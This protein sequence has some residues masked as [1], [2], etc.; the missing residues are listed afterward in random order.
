MKF[1]IGEEEF[2]RLAEDR[3]AIIQLKAKVNADCSPLELYASLDKKCA[4]L[5]ESVEKE[6]KHARFSFV[7]SQPDAIVTVKNRIISLDYPHKTDFIGLIEFSL[8]KVCEFYKGKKGRI[9]DGFDTMDV[10]RAAFS[11]KDVRFKG[12]GFDR[13]TFLGGAIGFCAYDMVYD[14]WLDISSGKS[15]T[16]DAQFALTTKTIV[17]DHLTNETFIVITPFIPARVMQERFTIRRLKMRINLL[18]QLDL[19]GLLFL[20]KINL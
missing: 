7:G 18:Q 15:P 17:F 13:Q 2:I 11:A 16:P 9:K 8:L 20:K 6:K 12:A 19:P 5:L 14:C 3:P 10:L 1:D 4:Y